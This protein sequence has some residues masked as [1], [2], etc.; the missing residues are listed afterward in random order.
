MDIVIGANANKATKHTAQELADHL[1]KIT[2]AKF[3]VKIGDGTNGIA[4]G[5]PDDFPK[6]SAAAYWPEIG[7]FDRENYLIKSHD[8][9]VYLV[10]ATPLAIKHAVWDFLYRIGY[11]Q[12]FPGKKWEIIP[13][14]PNLSVD[15]DI[16]ESPDYISRSI[17]YGHGAWDYAK[18][19]YVK[20]RE[21]N[22]VTSGFKLKTSH[23]YGKIIQR[24]KF[25]LDKHPEYYALID[26]KRKIRPNA[27][28]CISNDQLRRLVV[29]YALDYFNKN[30]SYD[31]ISMDPS[32]GGG[33]CE[34]KQCKALGSISDQALILANEVAV[35]INKSG[36]PSKKY[37]GMY[38]YGYHSPP[39]SISVHPNVIVSVATAFLKGG[40]LDEIIL[41]WRS[42]GAML[43]IR[44]YYSVN[45]WDR[46]MPSRAR[47]SNIDYLRRTIPRFYKDGAKF[48]NA[49]SGDNW[50][51]N[52]LGYYVAGRI[53]WDTKE[54]NRS[55]EL[56]DDFLTKAFGKAKA[57]MR[58]FYQ[59]IDG[60]KKHLIV[61]NQIG[62]MF[63][64]LAEARKL[65][66]SPEV[67]ERINDLVLY[68]HYVDLY[69]RYSNAKDMIR[70][71]RF[72]KLIQH[73]Y[74][75]RRTMMVHTK[76]LYKDLVRRDK[77]V[78]IPD[79]A[80]WKVPEENNPWKSSEPFSKSELESYLR[81]GVETY[82]LTNMDFEPI[83]V[84][85][86]LVPAKRLDLLGKSLGNTIKGRGVQ[87][88]YTW[89][90]NVATEIELEITGGLIKHYRDRGN[91][92]VDLWKVEEIND[93]RMGD[94]WVMQDRSVQPDGTPHKVILTAKE[95][96]LY[97]ITVSD[98]NDMSRVKWKSGIPMTFESSIDKPINIKGR[99]S[100]YFY[101]P[102]DTKVIGFYGG[103]AGKI[104]NSSGETVFS[105][106]GSK[107][108]YYS[109]PVAKGEDQKLWKISHA[110]YP[111]RLLTV[112]PFLALSSSEIMLPE[113]IVKK[114]P[115]KE[116]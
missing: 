40:V 12:Y 113:E 30:P 91:V 15:I 11:R 20:W 115:V 110:A 8:R 83:R 42:K 37:V 89:V 6:T 23:S 63:R 56:V 86:N 67:K 100:A 109:I 104:L 80:G 64:A 74:R 111:I 78:T 59:Q 85:H 77:T 72:E 57:P 26:G 18:E 22:R 7:T 101:V 49:E 44:E 106:K 46:D 38:A 19:P 2:T 4:V 24:E 75:M 60:S 61:D 114:E 31:T 97:K 5:L 76:A 55:D 52:G 17:W 107:L 82:Q 73:A 94:K 35:A 96:G 62:Q 87:T 112:P 28:F 21:R 54:A 66:I 13:H 39:P 1:G 33:W 103:K 14:E 16:E 90:D 68:A 50:G 105:L 34:C 79:G 27:K 58:I 51:P 47:G 71:K 48:M 92:R 81:D 84:S 93:M 98:G 116:K 29:T 45:T 36:E 88:F 41:G 108:G 65:A 3:E 95:T 102:K 43:G 32:D 70:Q 10:G 25:Q 69:S 53:L 9:G 99:Y